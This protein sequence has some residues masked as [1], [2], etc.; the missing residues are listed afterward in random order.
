MNWTGVTASTT[1]FSTNGLGVAWNGTRWVAGGQ[2]TN[3]IAYSSDGI[4]WTG[5]GLTAPAT[6]FTTA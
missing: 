1:I 5:L 3:S 4:T 2:G 6:P